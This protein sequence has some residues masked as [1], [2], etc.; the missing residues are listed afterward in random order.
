MI[1]L[2]ISGMALLITLLILPG[3]SSGQTVHWTEAEFVVW[4]A[5]TGFSPPAIV[6]QFDQESG[7]GIDWAK[8]EGRPWYDSSDPAKV[9]A[10]V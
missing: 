8:A 7:T 3:L 9:G 1:T 5:D 6:V 2:R 4:S 10:A